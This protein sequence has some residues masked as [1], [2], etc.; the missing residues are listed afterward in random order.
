M[1]LKSYDIPHF[2]P[3]SSAVDEALQNVI[4]IKEGRKVPLRT[5]WRVVNSQI[6]GL[7][8]GDEIVVAARTGTGKSAFVNLMI[9][10]LF[11]VN[12]TQKILC[13][14]WTF[15]MRPWR[16]VMR[17]Y[18]HEMSMTVHDL[19]SYEERLSDEKVERM[20][21]LKTQLCDYPIY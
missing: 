10:G 3:I 4:D 18:S 12:P 7:F 1:V 2:Q 9:K 13:L 6:G 16:Q 14:Y 20:K 11:D 15:E 17:L 19:L 21:L 5:S 8:A